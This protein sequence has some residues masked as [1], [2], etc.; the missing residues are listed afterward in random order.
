MAYKRCVPPSRAGRLRYICRLSLYLFDATRAPPV[1][2][3]KI[4]YLYLTKISYLYGLITRSFC[5]KMIRF[6]LILA[7]AL[8]LAGCR[9][10]DGFD[11]L[12]STS[13]AE[14]SARADSLLRSGKFSDADS[15]MLCNGVV[16]SRYDEGAYSRSEVRDII[17]SMISQGYLFMN[18]YTDYGG[19]FN[20]FSL[21]E[22]A[23]DRYPENSD[24]RGYVYTNMG[25]L[26]Q[27]G[28]L[29]NNPALSGHGSRYLDR[30]FDFCLEDSLWRVGSVVMFNL[31]ELH[32]ENGDPQRFL[33]YGRRWFA[34]RPP[35]DAMTRSVDHIVRGIDAY[36]RR[37]WPVAL[38]EFRSMRD[39]GDVD[40]V[41]AVGIQ[42][43]GA[44]YE[45]MTYEAMGDRERAS[46]ILDSLCARVE[47]IDYP[48]ASIW[49]HKLLGHFYNRRG[50]TSRAEHHELAY[51][52][53]IASIN[54]S[55]DVHSMDIMRVRLG[56]RELHD[57][58]AIVVRHDRVWRTV[59]IAGAVIALLLSLF[60]AYA[61]L[62]SRRSNRRI[63]S[64]YKRNREILAEMKRREAEEAAAAEAAIAETPKAEKYGGS[65]MDNATAD[66][67]VHRIRRVLAD[68]Q[69]YLSSDFSLRQLAQLVGSNT[70][71]VSQAI[72]TTTGRSFKELLGVKRVAEA[73]RLLTEGNAD[74]T[75]ETVANAV[76]FKS[77]TAFAAVFKQITGLTPTEFRN[78]ARK[79]GHEPDGRDL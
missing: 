33:P 2:T 78:A 34:A 62:M 43:K 21:A 31:S 76:G 17:R 24:L 74:M 20:M 9:P 55:K 5:L 73:C 25:A 44:Y 39:V 15:A 71:Y 46:A 58:N 6:L 13:T 59:L 61:L 3:D 32:F 40:S 64:L 67:L 22:R 66:I 70:A 30:A 72:N 45:A 10:D 4:F 79:A 23:I 60:L 12:L 53:A 42:C 77:R 68:P 36:C 26:T 7:T 38:R 41:T 29:L 56:I 27:L 69:Y 51:Y 48:Q 49:L 11:P 37:D 19:A 8:L 63:M 57:K 54:A 75:V 28:D 52:R 65:G 16:I 1:T 50:M 35:S 14:L 18:H 47:A